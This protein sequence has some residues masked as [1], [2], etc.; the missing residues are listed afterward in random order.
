M[1]DLHCV[2]GHE[3]QPQMQIASQQAGPLAG[4]YAPASGGMTAAGFLLPFLHDLG[5]RRYLAEIPGH[6]PFTGLMREDA[7]LRNFGSVQYGGVSAIEAETA[8]ARLAQHEGVLASA[9]DSPALA[10]RHIENHEY[11]PGTS[12]VVLLSNP[13]APDAARRG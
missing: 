10:W 1:M 9:S 8:Q 6:A 5:V 2:S 7:L 3:L 12:V 4:I 11:A 13:S